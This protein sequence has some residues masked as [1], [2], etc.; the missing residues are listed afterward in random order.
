MEENKYVARVAAK[1]E[2]KV[3]RARRAF[4]MSTEEKTQAKK[5]K[6]IWRQRETLLL[7]N[8]NGDDIAIDVVPR[9]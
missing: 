1:W 9:I 4:T 6:K 5:E 3:S 7:H 2:E 8:D